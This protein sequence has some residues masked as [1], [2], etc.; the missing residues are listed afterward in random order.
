MTYPIDPAAPIALINFLNYLTT[1]VFILICGAMER[2]LPEGLPGI[3][4]SKSSPHNVNPLPLP[5]LE[6]CSSE[7]SSVEAKDHTNYLVFMMSLN[8]LS[9]VMYTFGFKADYKRRRANQTTSDLVKNG[10]VL[11]VRNKS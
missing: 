10:A 3:Q 4:F 7:G 5:I 9:C 6:K 11:D 1:A 2:P 8:G